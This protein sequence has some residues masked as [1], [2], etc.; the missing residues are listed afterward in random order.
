MGRLHCADS[1]LLAARG[2]GAAGGCELAMGSGIATALTVDTA[3]SKSDRHLLG[4]YS[5]RGAAGH[6]CRAYGS[7]RRRVMKRHA[8][9]G[10]LRQIDTV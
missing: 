6:C 10:Y 7:Q 2:Y 8:V 1:T 3:A 4:Q 9:R 5:V